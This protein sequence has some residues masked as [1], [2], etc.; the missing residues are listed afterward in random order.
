MLV[1]SLETTKTK[2]N[3]KYPFTLCRKDCFLT[4]LMYTLCI[5]Y[6]TVNFLIFCERILIVARK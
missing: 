6:L 1:A 5:L 4:D 2:T 3:K